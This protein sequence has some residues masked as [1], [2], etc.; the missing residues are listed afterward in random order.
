MCAAAQAISSGNRSL[1]SDRTCGQRF[2]EGILAMLSIARI[3]GDDCAVG[4]GFPVNLD[5]GGADRAFDVRQLHGLVI[6]HRI[7]FL[8]RLSP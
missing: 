8:V 5:P 4:R 6:G 7:A 2:N 1:I 3:P